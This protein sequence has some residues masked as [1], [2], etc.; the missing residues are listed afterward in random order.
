MPTE[1]S[2]AEQKEAILELLYD[3]CEAMDTGWPVEKVAEMFTVDAVLECHDGPILRGRKQIFAHKSNPPDPV[4]RANASIHSF[5]NIRIRLS[6]DHR[7]ARVSSYSVVAHERFGKQTWHLG[8]YFIHLAFGADSRW[9]FSF[10]RVIAF[11]RIGY[12]DAR[13]TIR[14]ASRIPPRPDMP[15]FDPRTLSGAPD[16]WED[17]S[18]LY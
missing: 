5:T 15:N 17:R 1:L 12:P 3:Y 2:T 13:E 7:T 4:G 10:M 9:R 14:W 16:D 11:V 6:D 8:R 18:A